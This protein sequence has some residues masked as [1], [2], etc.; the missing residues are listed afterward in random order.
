MKAE[1]CRAGSH[2]LHYLHC[3]LNDLNAEKSQPSGDLN[4]K[5]HA[6]YNQAQHYSILEDNVYT[7]NFEVHCDDSQIWL[8]FMV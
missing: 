8:L 2:Y 7:H 5:Q 3:K 4:P 1:A 6:V